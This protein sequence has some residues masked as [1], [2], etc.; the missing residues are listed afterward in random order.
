MN[1]E[2][3]KA[4][5]CPQI[6]KESAAVE[7]LHKFV[8][9]CDVVIENYRVGHNGKRLGAGYDESFQKDHPRLIL[10]EIQALAHLVLCGPRWVLI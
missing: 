4:R 2:P 6:S 10:C 9:G 5:D 1:D 3:H 7:V 8:A